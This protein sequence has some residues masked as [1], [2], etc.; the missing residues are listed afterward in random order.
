M[1][2]EYINYINSNYH[3]TVCTDELSISVGPLIQTVSEGGIARFIATATGIKIRELEYEWF[4]F[5]APESII[6]GRKRNLIINNVRV[7]NE[8]LYYSCVKNEWNN[9]N[10]SLKVNLVI[11]SKLQDYITHTST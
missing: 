6:V 8:G 1:V 10:C 4:K 2:S 5:E 11:N 9:T 3:C 7:G